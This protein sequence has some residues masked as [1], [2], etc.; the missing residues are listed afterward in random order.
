MSKKSECSFVAVGA[1]GISKGHG[2]TR[3]VSFIFL[4]S[5]LCSQTHLATQLLILRGCNKHV[6][7][8]CKLHLLC[9]LDDDTVL[10][11]DPFRRA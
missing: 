1:L 2:S 11:Q 4:Y 9:R 7:H 6:T 3:Q 5:Q 10:Q 8:N